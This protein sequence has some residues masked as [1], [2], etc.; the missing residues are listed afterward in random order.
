MQI[1]LFFNELSLAPPAPDIRAARSLMT[2]LII[3]IKQLC[4]LRVRRELNVH[5]NFDNEELSPNY[6]IANWK[7]D[8]D[9]DLEEVRY[10]RSL[11]TKYGY[12]EESNIKIE[13]ESEFFYENYKANG[14]GKAYLNGGIA[15][16]IKSALHWEISTIN[17]KMFGLNETGEISE[18]VCE[19]QHCSDES[20]ISEKRLWIEKITAG[21][22]SVGNDIWKNREGFFSSLI[23][24]REVEEHLQQIKDS[25]AVRQ[26]FLHLTALQQNCEDW[27]SG[28]FDFEKIRGKVT[29]ESKQTLSQYEIEHTFTLP[30]NTKQVFSYHVRFT[31][32]DGR[33]F[34]EV[35]PLRRKIIIGYIGNKLP[36][37]SYPT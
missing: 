22:L 12:S 33:I 28:F 23:F 2:G 26:I 36:N 31:P 19:V 1:E 32:G 34:F 20:H 25:R 30:D 8:K 3:V 27:T 4:K 13:T 35:D 29:P 15:V 5:E 16:S 11:R 17:I 7:Y 24:C 9:T 10:L 6:T 14:L 18:T 37:V 21:K